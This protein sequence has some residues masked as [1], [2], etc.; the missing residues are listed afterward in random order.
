MPLTNT[1]HKQAIESIITL[2]DTLLKNPYY[3]YND[4]TATLVDYCNINV[5][6]TTLDEAAKIDYAQ[7]GSDSPIRF[8]LIHDMYVYGIDLVVVN[9]ESGEYGL[10]SGEITGEAIILPNTI[11]P[12]P[13]DYFL[14]NHVK[15]KY[16]FKVISANPDTLEDGANVW[17]IE[18][19]LDQ[20]EDSRI[21]PL[22]VNEY[23]FTVHNTGTK[24]NPIIQKDKY[25]LA[26]K[27]DDICVALK[28]FYK[29]MYYNPKVQTFTFLFAFIDVNE[30][31]GSN[32]GVYFYDP[33]LIEF[34]I[35]NKILDG[36]GD[37]YMYIVHQ[38]KPGPG[39]VINYTKSI[40]KVL[41]DKDLDNIEACRTSSD[42]VYID[43]RLSIFSTR[44]EKY[45][46]L[47]YATSPLSK[48]IIDI[49][50]PD[51]KYHIANGELYEDINNRK[52]N[53]LIKYFNDMEISIEDIIPFDSI[54]YI[55][56]G[57]E[58]F[59]LLPM[60]IFCLESYIKRLIS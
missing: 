30:C 34:L 37:E 12:Y 35:N 40:W 15:K 42:F 57:S 25:D 47:T 11:Q 18:Y 51:V 1:V 23:V 17:K 53:L 55:D 50:D 13:G 39:F 31:K 49:L 60:I 54:Q 8:N 6:M 2:K 9:L 43:D 44:Y 59:F 21:R 58:Y 16:L 22:I 14:I 26:T 7:I 56:N 4:K 41:E 52:Y 48:R 38:T 10:E 46:S 27:L 28:K 32:S 36:D 33:Y 20:L 45:F 19:K 5:E 3:L 29:S 24:F